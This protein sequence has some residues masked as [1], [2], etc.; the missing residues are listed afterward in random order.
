[1]RAWFDTAVVGEV[2]GTV[3]VV[4]VEVDAV[5]GVESEGTAG[6]VAP[7]V[8]G[9]DVMGWPEAEQSWAKFALSSVNAVGRA[10]IVP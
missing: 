8:G 3:L 2:A 10:P 4:D 5:P 6:P 7:V 9:A 1:L